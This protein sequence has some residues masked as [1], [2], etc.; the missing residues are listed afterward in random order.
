M[1]QYLDRAKDQLEYATKARDE[2]DYAAAKR[3]FSQAAQY[4]LQAAEQSPDGL[5]QSRLAATKK[6]IIHAETMDALAKQKQLRQEVAI[7]TTDGK[8][9][10]WRVTEKPDVTFD[11]VAGL[12]EVKQQ[13]R[14]KFILPFE[15]QD[16]AEYY[17]IGSGGGI[18]LYGPPGTGKTLIAKATA[19][20]LEA[21]FFVV[22]ASDIMSKWVGKAEENVNRLFEAA[23]SSDRAVIFI[24]EIDALLPKRRGNLSTVMKR[25]VPQFLAE[26]DGF[27]G[28][29]SN[30]LFIGATN[31]PWAMDAAV[32]RPGRFDAR[33]YIPLPDQTTRHRIL[34]IHLKGRPLAEDVNLDALAALMEGYSG[35][36]VAAVCHRAS[37]RAFMEAIAE[38]DLPPIGWDDFE[39]ALAE[40]KPSVDAK[41]LKRYEE[42]ANRL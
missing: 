8:T 40:I 34:E 4:M 21:T 20:E 24:D 41:N 27:G 39:A 37:Q 2:G 38:N 3:H 13:I 32:L 35:A 6:I 25:V 23:R 16:K 11:D 12:E 36:D 17:G 31:E 19:G 5:K 15:H 9:P 28:R 42:Y 30:V 26:M 29:A 1:R 14:L 22:K 7:P 10:A 33:I 18:L